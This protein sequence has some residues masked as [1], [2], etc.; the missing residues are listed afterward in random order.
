VSNEQFQQSVQRSVK[1]GKSLNQIARELRV[2]WAAVK[3]AAGGQPV[4]LRSATRKRLA[5]NK[6]AL[7]NLALVKTATR[8]PKCAAPTASPNVVAT[9]VQAL[10]PQLRAAGI[11]LLTVNLVTGEVQTVQAQTWSVGAD[12]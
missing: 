10:I 6:V 8:A 2:P 12:A 7:A 9:Q 4:T 3:K 5:N 1:A 11:Q